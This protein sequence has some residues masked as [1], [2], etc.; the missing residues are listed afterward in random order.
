[1][2]YAIKIPFTEPD[3]ENSWL[4]VTESQRE[5]FKD[6]HVKVFKTKESA[7]KAAKI[8]KKYKVVEYQNEN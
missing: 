3:D 8:W 4:F 7:L 2:K 6:V 5:D 1:M